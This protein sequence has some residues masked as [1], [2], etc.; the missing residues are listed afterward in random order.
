MK[1]T[2]KISGLI[3]S[4]ILMCAI[5]MGFGQIVSAQVTTFA[6]FLE[7]NGTQDFIFTN[8][9]GVSGTFS[10]ISGGSPIF[11]IYQNVSNLPVEL[12]GFQNAHLFIST[13]TTTP[14]TLSGSNLTQP[15]DAIST[16][17]IIRDT[18]TSPGV[19]TGSRTNLLTATF[20]GA[21][22]L[23]TVS[24]G[25]GGNSATLSAATPS[26][27]VTFSSDFVGFGLSTQRNLALSF[28]SV[29]TSYTSGAGGFLDSFTAAG[30]GTF[31]S[32]PPPGYFTPTAAP[33]TVSGRVS[34][35]FGTG[36]R[37]AVVTM[38]DSNGDI[39]QATTNHFGRFAFSDVSA[40][41]TYVFDVQ[42]KGYSFS[43]QVVNVDDNIR[44]LDFTPGFSR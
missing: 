39:R 18:P 13:T 44:N 7:R 12:Q 38:S 11:F 32:S 1:K 40:G 15:L 34:N 30:T 24:G 2:N 5:I 9:G 26:N 4:L 28:S 16:V 14:A 31:S 37:H 8:N 20:S 27:N 17:Q 3:P 23:P 19:G 35:V 41:E 29:I 25:D 42:A 43:Q 21:A 10:N 6:Q 36:I 22:G 33:V